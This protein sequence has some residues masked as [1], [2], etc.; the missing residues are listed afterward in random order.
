MSSPD[1]PAVEP[2][3]S[4][5]APVT[6]QVAFIGGATGPWHVDRL[7]AVVGDPCLVYPSWKVRRPPL[8]SWRPGS[9]AARSA[10]NATSIAPNGSGSTSDRLHHADAFEDLV[11]PGPEWRYVRH[12]PHSGPAVTRS[13]PQHR[14]GTAKTNRRY[15]IGLTDPRRLP[16][17]GVL[18]DLA[19]VERHT[20]LI[21]NCLGVVAGW[22]RHHLHPDR[23]RA[24]F[25]RP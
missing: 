25:R 23:C 14:R 9:G 3:A 19:E 13:C 12:P 20:R 16:A 10:T 11:A 5:V 18:G 6:A 21:A 7:E 8:P 22:D 1:P 15:A 2:T 4:C 17:P 24:S